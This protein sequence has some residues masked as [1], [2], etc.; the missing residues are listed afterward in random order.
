MEN[1]ESKFLKGAA[2]LGIAGILVKILGA[3]YRIP[4]GNLIGLEGMGYYQTAYPFYILALTASTAGFP[5]AIAKMVSEKRALGDYGGAKKV[6][7]VSLVILAIFGLLSA[8]FLYFKAEAIVNKVDNPGAYY[9][10][11]ALS[12]ALFFVPIMSV[13]RGYFQGSHDMVPTAISQVFEQFFRVVFGIYLAYTFLSKGLEEAAGGASLGGTIGALAGTIV[14]ILI[15]LKRKS[16]IDK[17]IENSIVKEIIPT[18]SIIKDLLLIAIPITIGAAITPLM[19]LID[20]ELVMVR[21]QDI[22]F[23]NQRANVLFGALKGN[24]Q[25][26]INL[27]QTFAMALCASIVPA[28]SSSRAEGDIIGEGK[29]ISAGIKITLMIAVAAAVGLFVLAVD[30]IGL[31][32]FKNTPEEI[33][34]TGRILQTLSIGVIF[35]MLLQISSSMLQGLGKPMLAAINL[36]IGLI[37]KAVLTYFLTGVES[38]NVFGAAIS[39]V[40]TYLIVAF[41]NLRMVLKVSNA[42][43]HI[44]DGLKKI[45]ISAIGMGVIIKVLDL[46]LKPVLIGLNIMSINK[47]SGLFTLGAVGVG[48]LSYGLLLLKT[49]AITDS[50]LALIPKG[51]KIKML[52]DRFGR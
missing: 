27:P 28:I 33:L 20:L 4:L 14:V 15:Y 42:H 11:V 13:F 2:I 29:I 46:F 12:P 24:A 22:G 52:L 45:T 21:L 18:K 32:Y 39:T 30:I 43:I 9:A 10:L 47:M 23:D 34:L 1:R 48:G 36:F 35:V 38:L 3:F 50:D 8:G 6:F 31:L 16:S 7:Q 17:E 19:D 26:L 51:D 41:L 5:V 37:F 25:T 44:I 49:G 40:I